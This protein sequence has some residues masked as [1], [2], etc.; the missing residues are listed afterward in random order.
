MSSVWRCRVV[1]LSFPLPWRINEMTIFLGLG[2]IVSTVSS[3]VA[4]G[5]AIIAYNHI[6]IIT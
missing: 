3:I 6:I 2:I 5:Y 1:A 4:V